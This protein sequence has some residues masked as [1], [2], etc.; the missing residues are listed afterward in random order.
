MAPDLRDTFEQLTSPDGP[1]F[2]EFYNIYADSI[3]LRERKTRGQI[4]DMLNSPDYRNYCVKRGGAVIGFSSLFAP[5]RESFCLLE[6]MAIGSAHRGSGVGKELFQHSVC[7]ITSERG[8]IPVLLEVDSEREPSP[9]REVRLRRKRFYKSLGCFQIDGLAYLFPLPGWGTPPEMDLMVYVPIGFPP[10]RKATIE[11]WLKV[12]YQQ[13]Y[14]CGPDDP[15][16]P[17]MM[18]SVADPLQLFR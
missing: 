16:I 4:S 9:D 7:S 12:V 13:V 15:R 14:G 6:Y 11:H 18:K 3:P 8:S 1:S 2:E 5:A 17:R 10:I